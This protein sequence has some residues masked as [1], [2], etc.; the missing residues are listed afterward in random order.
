MFIE[1]RLNPTTQVI[2]LWK[3]DWEN[4][5]GAP[6]HKVTLEKIGAERKA[7]VDS[8]SAILRRAAAICWAYGRTLGNLAV[9]DQS[10]L[11][12]FPGEVGTDAVLPCDIVEAGKFRYGPPRW[13]CRT[14]QLHWGT[15]ADLA[16][17]EVLGEMR[18][19]N[20]TQKMNYVI[21]PLTINMKEFAEVGI[22]CS[23]P[24]AISTWEIRARPPRIHVHLR[25][26][27]GG[28]KEVDKDFHAIS[29][30]YQLSLGMFE[31]DI[32]RVNVTPPAAYEFVLALEAGRELN[33]IDCT[34]CGY[35]HLDLGSFAL[36]PHKK[37]FCANCG[38]DSIFSDT[39]IVSTPLKPL[40]DAF[41]NSVGFEVP[42]RN[43]DLGEYPGCNY[44]LWA[45]TPAI[46]WT[47]KRPQEKGIHVHVHR[48]SG[49]RFIDDT[50]G[51]VTLGGKILVREDLLD[52]MVKRTIV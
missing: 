50:F 26:T 7:V 29:L 18:C 24:A 8:P 35:P 40:H 28:L 41:M 21:S 44:A 17:Y 36:K 45:S 13:W 52:L 6:A 47:A 33:C 42:A 20:Q 27:P 34:Y 19:A 12:S 48:P 46:L 31:A 11:G 16:S 3:C 37:H 5:E 15:K 43:I 49:E 30:D 4:R 25:K 10:M 32:T 39:K 2:E 22:W 51:E 14:H 38:R 1:R 9:F 23:M